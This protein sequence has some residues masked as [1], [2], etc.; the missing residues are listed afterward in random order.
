MAD[1]ILMPQI[2]LGSTGAPVSG[3][4]IYVYD[5][6]TTTPKTVYTDDGLTTPHDTPIEADGDGAPPPIFLSGTCK[7]DA[8]TPEG[9]SLPGFPRDNYPTTPT[10]GGAASLTSFSPQTGNPATDVQEAIEGCAYLTATNIDSTVAAAFR[11]ALVSGITAGSV[12]S[13]GMFDC[14]L[15]TDQAIGA[16]IAGSNLKWASTSSGADDISGT[17]P[18]G[19]WRWMSTGNE[20]G[21][22]VRIA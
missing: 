17:S 3:A 2:L 18:S 14:T 5:E 4:L 9:V 20:I 12:G 15:G 22:A 8:K 10:T 6:G 1:Q 7:V 21:L 19:T 11:T 13:Y 16:N